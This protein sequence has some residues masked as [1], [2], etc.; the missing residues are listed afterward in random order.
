MTRRAIDLATVRDVRRRLAEIAREHPHALAPERLARID[1]RTIAM[2]TKVLSLRLSED[3][4]AQVEQARQAVAEQNPG[5][6]I[7]TPDTV[8]ML[9]VEALQ[10]RGIATRPGG[11]KATATRRR[12]PAS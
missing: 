1:E 10:A 8:R 7:S 11:N 3:L 12:N 4:L 9:V 6:A 2:A 5:L